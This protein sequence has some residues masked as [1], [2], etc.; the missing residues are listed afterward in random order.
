M[1]M[2]AMEIAYQDEIRVIS[3]LSR[4]D[5]EKLIVDYLIP[6]LNGKYDLVVGV[7][8][9]GKPI[10]DIVAEKLG[11]NVDY[12]R[13]SRNIGPMQPA[14]VR[15]E[16]KRSYGKNPLFVDDACANGCTLAALR[17]V[18]PN[19]TFASLI[20][21]THL[22]QPTSAEEAWIRY[23]TPKDIIIGA[24]SENVEFNWEG[25]KFPLPKREID[26]ELCPK[27]VGFDFH[28]KEG[29]H[30]LDI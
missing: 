4:E 15:V 29:Y 16:G 11:L 5:A 23:L 14:K 21:E 12:V 27:T 9:A 2:K 24:I 26:L 6:K 22:F 1:K 18:Y 20:G 30:L 8:N 7:L 3:R 28:S 25:T 13:C 17:E 19:G 10:A